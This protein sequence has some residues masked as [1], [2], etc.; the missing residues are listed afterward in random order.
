MNNPNVY[1]LSIG[2]NKYASDK[3]SNLDGC[4]KDVSD[5]RQVMI[6]LN[7]VDDENCKT[8]CNE[9]AT[10]A[11]I[12]HAFRTH[13]KQLK[14]GDIAILHYSGHGS[15][16]PTHPAFIDAGYEMK[17]SKNEALVCHDSRCSGIF[18]IADKELRLLIA[19]VQKDKKETTFVGLFDCCHAGSILKEDKWK[20]RRDHPD[21]KPRPLVAYLD[22]IYQ[23]MLQDTGSVILPS[24]NYLALTAC[25]P[26]EQAL[27]TNN[28]GL[29]TNAII[30]LLQHPRLYSYAEIHS[31][32]RLLVQR[33]S[34]RRQHPYLEYMG[35]SNPYQLFLKKTISVINSM[36]ALSK[37]G[38]D[39]V[40][41][42]G[43]I[44]GIEIPILSNKSIPI[45]Q[46]KED[47]V[48]IGTATVD[49]V[50]VE[51]TKVI[52]TWYDETPSVTDQ[53][54]VGL[55]H[56]P[57]AIKSSINPDILFTRQSIVVNEEAAY[58]VVAEDNQ[59]LIYKKKSD[60]SELIIGITE[61]GAKALDWLNHQ[62]KYI[63]KW[64]N[65]LQLKTPKRTR[66]ALDTI[67]FY[68]SFWDARGTQIRKRVGKT[69]ED[70]SAIQ[71]IT[72]PIDSTF[73]TIFYQLEI[74]HQYPATHGLYFYL[75][76]LDR[77]YGIKQKN[78]HY[79]KPIFRNQGVTLYDSKEMG[80]A[81]GI[82]D[83]DTSEAVDTFLLIASETALSNPYHFY[84]TGFGD[85][86]GKIVAYQ[87][88]Q[89]MKD[90]VGV[91]NSLK[92]NWVV[93]KLEVRLKRQ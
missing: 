2:I 31:L 77:K 73:D 51:E 55:Y 89:K 46:K 8:I 16:E 47:L 80:K 60:T 26:Q 41:N 11:G 78:E 10:R 29:F 50:F 24:I 69:S 3:V 1:L 28:G 22:G 23:A 75:L 71:Q 84:Q 14:D 65:I 57:L 85:D 44:Q 68:F 58:E 93:K 92:S 52:P 36:P 4:E 74:V 91:G 13:F 62:L 83:P 61:G 67:S 19:E 39:W 72:I 37:R 12:I 81:L 79:I 18:N 63:A 45:F 66:I 64:E 35:E 32:S 43:A 9:A 42:A 70:L 88:T 25:S 56:K 54:F 34:N 17:E 86:F 90:E 59:L 27:E 82:S 6:Q 87:A 53:L 20:I 33:E 76:H 40:A 38:Q 15:Q 5:L 49:T 30:E 7:L 48:P 21:L